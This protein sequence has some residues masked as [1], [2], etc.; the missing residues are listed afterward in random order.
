MKYHLC[1]IH[2]DFA[3][4]FNSAIVDLLFSW[5]SYTQLITYLIVNLVVHL[6]CV[7]TR[8]FF[9][10]F[11]FQAT[12]KMGRHFHFSNYYVYIVIELLCFYFW[13]ES[14]NTDGNA[15]L[16][17]PLQWKYEIWYKKFKLALF[18]VAIM[19]FPEWS[20]V[21]GAGSGKYAKCKTESQ[22][23]WRF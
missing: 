18:M 16:N 15:T 17:I 13:I 19:I 10:V 23:R 8:S 2:L 12:P 14:R 20:D 7:L 21:E 9:F 3:I 4:Q 11:S 5:Q 6:S 1:D 22:W